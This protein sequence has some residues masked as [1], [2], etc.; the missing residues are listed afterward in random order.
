MKDNS[1]INILII[2]DDAIDRLSL[3]RA[4]KAG[5]DNLN[6]LEATTGAE[7]IHLNEQHHFDVLLVDYR[8]PDG[9]GLDFI[10]QFVLRKTRNTAIV[11]LTRHEDDSLVELALDKGAHDFLLKDEVNSRRLIRAIR[12]A[13]HRDEL[14]FKLAQKNE[15]LKNLAQKDSLTGLS[16]RYTFEQFLNTL[17][18]RTKRH[19]DERIVVLFLDLDNFKKINDELGHHVGDEVLK[20]V[21]V[22]LKRTMRDSDFLARLGGDEFVLLSQDL[23]NDQE[24]TLFAERIIEELTGKPIRVNNSDLSITTSVGI[25][26]LGAYAHSAS[27]LMICADIAMYNSKN[28]GG[29]QYSLYTDKLHHDVNFKS[30]RENDLHSALANNQFELHY[31]AQI[32]SHTQQLS[33]MEALIRWNHPELGRLGPGE[34]IDYAEN[35]GLMTDIGT[36]VLQEACTQLKKWQNQYSLEESTITIAVNLSASHLQSSDL[37]KN[38]ISVLEDTGLH[39]NCLELEI[40]ENSLIFDLQYI[41]SKL[42]ELEKQGVR[43]SLDD[44]GTGYSSIQHLHIFPIDTLKIDKSFIDG[45]GNKITQNKLLL[46]MIGFAKALDLTVVAEG[47]ETLAQ[48]EFCK[49]NGCDLIQGYFYSKPLSADEFEEKFFINNNILRV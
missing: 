9:N 29:N 1:L 26:M 42:W 20:Q 18:A 25:A 15:Q 34:F 24:A 14:E 38:V 19:L 49:S 11:M 10:E 12:Q 32:D 45:C 48:L 28:N 6:I 47:V 44:F 36:W 17:Y 21:A 27:E 39:P 5:Y 23:K 40:T 37:L 22:R 33:G 3:K 41:S 7:G 16:N 2:D 43:L 35:L 46:A 4:L 30:K 31:Q 13:R 8:L